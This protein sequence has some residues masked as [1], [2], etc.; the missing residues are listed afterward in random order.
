MRPRS[1]W[2]R[3]RVRGAPPSSRRQWC[4]FARWWRRQAPAGAQH[5]W[6]AHAAAGALWLVLCGLPATC[7]WQH[8]SL[9]AHAC[10]AVQRTRAAPDV[11]GAAA[12]PHTHAAQAYSACVHVCRQCCCVPRRRCVS[13]KAGR[14]ALP[15]VGQC[16]A[17]R[18]HVLPQL[19]CC[20]RRRATQGSRCCCRRCQGV[21]PRGR[22]LYLIPLC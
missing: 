14:T 19:W 3:V 7:S 9:C 8:R 22:A 21:W 18:Q 2:G 10:T 12:V 16:C 5:V 13:R 6:H 20:N 11:L 1:V 17:T 15:F 4:C